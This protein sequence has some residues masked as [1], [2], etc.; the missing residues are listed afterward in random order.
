[1]LPYSNTSILGGQYGC[2][3]LGNLGNLGNFVRFNFIK[4][5]ETQVK[6]V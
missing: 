2:K 3:A 1:M 5:K 6:F 4:C